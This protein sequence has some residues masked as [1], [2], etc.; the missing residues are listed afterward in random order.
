MKKVRIQIEV[1]SDIVCPW[2][3]IGKA[4][5]EKAMAASSD[6]FDFEVDYFPFELDPLVP[7]NGHDYQNYMS[8]K[9]GHAS[10]FLQVAEHVRAVAAGEGIEIDLCRQKTYP[11]TRDAH[12]IILLAREDDKQGQVVN[13]FFRGFFT[14]GADLSRKETLL[15]IGARAGLDTGKI[16][17]MLESNTGKSQIEMAQKKLKD[18]GI[19]GVPLFILDNRFVITGAQS[20]DAFKKAFE[21]IASRIQEDVELQ[22][23]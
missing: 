7:E 23:S 18:L 8:Q 17:L 22:N 1:V 10:K 13:A 3:Y 11:N 4:R 19:T 14:E 15:S 6:R 9:F 21:E 5:L 16:S 12:R 20:V 2:C